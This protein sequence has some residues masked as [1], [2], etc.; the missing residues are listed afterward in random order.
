MDTCRVDESLPNVRICVM[1]R[2]PVAGAAKTR[3]APA[4]GAAGA[5]RLQRRLLRRSVELAIEAGMGDVALWCAPDARHPAFRALACAYPVSLRVQQGADLGERMQHIFATD[6]AMRPVLLIGTDCPALETRHLRDAA[7]ALHAGND[8]VLL[9]AE[10][11]GYVLVGLRRPQPEVFRAIDWSTSR[12]MDQTRTR[13]RGAGLRWHEGP[14]LWD[15]D[16]PADL[17]RLATLALQPN[18]TLFNR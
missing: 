13:L 7:A 18:G 1:S 12:V 15:L 5:A 9:P 14:T 4:L 6:G 17:P 2:A 16:Q 3:L 10:D 11:G 8:A